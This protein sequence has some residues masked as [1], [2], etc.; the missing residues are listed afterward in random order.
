MHPNL[1]GF[2]DTEFLPIFE[3]LDFDHMQTNLISG[4][5]DVKIY[6][7]I[8]FTIKFAKSLGVIL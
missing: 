3:S 8:T 6:M 4:S 7:V 1:K 2:W 5:H